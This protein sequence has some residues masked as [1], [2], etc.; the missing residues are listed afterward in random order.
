LHTAI[1]V[2]SGNY[3][4]YIVNS[5][6]GYG[7]KTQKLHYKLHDEL[8]CLEWVDSHGSGSGWSTPVIPSDL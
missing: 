1:L 7:L 2:S 8:V 6:K 3:W 4:N 5:L